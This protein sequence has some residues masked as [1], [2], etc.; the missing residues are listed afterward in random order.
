MTPM[1]LNDAPRTTMLFKEAPKLDN[2][3]KAL[4]GGMDLA[5]APS[6]GAPGYW[7]REKTWSDDAIPS[8]LEGRRFVVTGANSGIGKAAT[9][10]L[11]ARGA[12]VV[13]VC[14]SE[15]RGSSA[16]EEIQNKTGNEGLEL[17]L[18][19]LSLMSQAS[20]IAKTLE[21]GPAVDAIVH[22][23]GAL[24]DE[25]FITDE[26]FETTFALHVASPYLIN[27]ALVDSFER[28]GTRI[29][30]VSSGGMYTQRLNLE[31]LTQGHESFDGVIAYA[32]CK[33]AQVILAD[34]FAR[35]FDLI[36]NSMHP[37]WV[38]TPGVKT[39]L[40]QFYELTRSFLRTPEQGAD[41]IVWMAASEQAEVS[42]EFFL[43]REARR[44]HIP[45]R[46]TRS[47][48]AEIEALWQICEEA[49]GPYRDDASR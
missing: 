2:I 31:S 9:Q 7:A 14:R 30:W 27:R 25:K 5:V 19:D 44:K 20:K 48:D 40:P 37:G 6:F 36:S 35:R 10:D 8:S 11:A 18:A 39:S 22:N 49:T 33:R 23:A 32:Q 21:A 4:A 1:H 34:E 29:V 42:G 13:M 12:Q 3:W 43:D 38:D 17:E 24:F 26:G 45:L 46:D 28:W 47:T 16:L 41:T 15:E